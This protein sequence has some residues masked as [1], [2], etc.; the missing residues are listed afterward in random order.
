MS[1]LSGMLKTAWFE[2]VIVTAL[3]LAR[4]ERSWSQSRVIAELQRY[5]RSLGVTLPSPS[6]L[7][8]ELSRWENGH[9]APD[10]FYQRL[11]E[12]VYDRSAADLG[13]VQPIADAAPLVGSTWEEYLVSASELWKR[14]LS[15]R[16]FLK[17]T[18]FAAAG[19]AAP[20]L[21]A[22]VSNAYASPN[23]AI[24]S[25]TVGASQV[26]FIQEMTANLA[27]FDNRYGGGQVRHAAVAF[28]DGEVAPLLTHGRYSTNTGRSLLQATAE[29]ARLVGWMT[30]DVGRHG[31]AQRYLIQALQL[32]EAAGDRALM[33]E[34]LAAMSQQSTYMGEPHQAVDLARSA[35]TLAQR[36]GLSALV[37]EASVMEAHGLARAGESTSC[38]R[39]LTAAEV[40]LD[41]AD[42]SSDPHWI[43]YFDEAY[44]SAKFGHCLREL[45]DQD[46]AMRFAERSLQMNPGYDR[47]R[48][49]NL[50]LLA[51]SH[52][53]RGAI[54]EAC[55]V[56]QQAV[57]AAAGMRSHRVVK[58]LR[59]FRRAL[60][61][62]EK[63][64]DVAALDAAL[65]PILKAA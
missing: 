39:A 35:R 53:Q 40:A 64:A 23:R 19:F 48:V 59:D 32:A 13:I 60:P 55:A 8:T 24:G 51:H 46:Q 28:L 11:F 2:E 25:P 6:S 62:A 14:D 65:S 1:G 61:T 57:A 41:R 27:T 4:T 16:D 63:S 54:S 34:T 58:H 50:T 12:M 56:G 44:L 7:K 30:H 18:T 10:V 29:L 36:E 20:S 37:A 33:S 52:A 21:H 47:G 45:G 22:L 9:R 42:R 38:A 49:F 3:R 31:L 15:R 43:G 17:S 26:S 5:A